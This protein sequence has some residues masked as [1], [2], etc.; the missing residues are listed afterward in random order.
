MVSWLGWYVP[1]EWWYYLLKIY[2]CYSGNW[3]CIL[4][5]FGRGPKQKNA[6][7]SLTNRRC[8]FFCLC[9]WKG[10]MTFCQRR[11]WT[12]FSTY[13]CSEKILLDWVVFHHPF[14]LSFYF[15]LIPPDFTW[16]S[17]F[18]CNTVDLE[19]CPSVWATIRHLFL[20]F[21]LAPS[22][23]SPSALP[24]MSSASDAIAKPYIHS[25][26]NSASLRYLTMRLYFHCSNVSHEIF[27][28]FNST[29]VRIFLTCWCLSHCLINF[30][31]YV[32][33][34]LDWSRFNSVKS[35]SRP[36]EVISGIWPGISTMKR[37]V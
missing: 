8:D 4:I 17:R 35:Q 37:K 30:E 12:G 2:S 34:T 15:Y 9:V 27:K 10:V 28:R 3:G 26:S 22:I 31:L 32:E 29:S 18:Y 33:L 16:C 23:S 19:S 36:K 6:K 25:T 20:P 21:S 13:C 1:G 14:L 24:L 11:Y 5:T 7:I